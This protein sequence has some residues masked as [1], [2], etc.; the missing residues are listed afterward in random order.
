MSGKPI[1]VSVSP[2]SL[3]RN[4]GSQKRKNHQIGSV[5]NFATANAQVCR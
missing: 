2:Y 3:F 1:V 5:M 4:F